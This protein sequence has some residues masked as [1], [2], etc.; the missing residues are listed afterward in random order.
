M[1]EEN[2]KNLFE[3]FKAKANNTYFL[4]PKGKSGCFCWAEYNSQNYIAFSGDFDGKWNSNQQRENEATEA[5]KILFRNKSLQRCHLKESFLVWIPYT[6][7]NA[8]QVKNMPCMLLSECNY[9]SLEHFLNGGGVLE[10]ISSYCCERKIL[11]E[12]FFAEILNFPNQ[13]IN[14]LL[15]REVMPPSGLELLLALNKQ[16]GEIVFY[17][18]FEPCN[19]CMPLFSRFT[20]YSIKYKKRLGDYPYKIN[21]GEK[22]CKYIYPT[23]IK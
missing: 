18:K 21:F 19:F 16:C 13:F 5:I 22:Y 12:I 3:K 8:D 7:Y 4:K 9:Q 1:S 15:H 2:I 17:S 10:D 20:Y 6:A 11:G 23:I 14:L